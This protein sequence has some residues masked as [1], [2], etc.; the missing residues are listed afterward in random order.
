MAQLKMMIR[1]GVILVHK[2]IN[3]KYLHAPSLLTRLG[4]VG[5]LLGNCGRTA[6]TFINFYIGKLCK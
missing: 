6:T 4:L 2:H 5:T 1:I 3:I